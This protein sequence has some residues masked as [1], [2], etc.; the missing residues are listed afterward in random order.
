MKKCL[1]TILCASTA[2]VLC[3]CVSVA[4][5]SS[6]NFDNFSPCASNCNAVSS[7]SDCGNVVYEIDDF[8]SSSN[9]SITGNGSGIGCQY[10]GYVNPV[11]L[12]SGTNSSYTMCTEYK[13][14][15]IESAYVLYL[16]AGNA[17][18][19]D[20]TIA[21]YDAGTCTPPSGVSITHP[22][23]TLPGKAIGLTPGNDYVVCHTYT[24]NGCAGTSNIYETCISIVEASYCTSSPDPSALTE[25]CSGENFEIT[26]D[27][28][29]TTDPDF[30]DF[31]DGLPGFAVFY[32]LDGQ[33]RYTNF[34]N[35][36]TAYNL[37]GNP[38]VRFYDESNFANGGGC[39]PIRMESKDNT[40]CTPIDIPVGI[41]GIDVNSVDVG[42]INI[43]SD[44]PV[45]GAT[46][47][48]HPQL[49]SQVTGSNIQLIS[50]GGTVCDTYSNSSTSS[51][52][53]TSLHEIVFGGGLSGSVLNG[54]GNPLNQT[55]PGRGE[56]GNVIIPGTFGGGGSGAT[57]IPDN[58]PCVTP[59]G[60]GLAVNNND[61]MLLEH[62]VEV[63]QEGHLVFN[64]E[65]PVQKAKLY[66]NPASG[67]L[68]FSAGISDTYTVR[69]YDTLGKQVFTGQTN[70]DAAIDIQ[71]LSSGLYTYALED[72]RQNIFDY[73]KWVKK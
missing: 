3:I 28:M 50:Q 19:I 31:T 36:M 2:F 8:A 20:R 15:S 41:V 5:A 14:S 63:N 12:S 18:C 68:F 53:P 67:Q 70:D 71:H 42:L 4:N 69:I 51:G 21:V 65:L 37:Q 58:I 11:Q 56:T 22:F 46:L 30:Y 29:C 38:N 54:S 33:G 32:Y 43:I 55:R 7:A 61:E 1:F 66:P 9:N 40:D 35:N 59:S 44:C 13:A 23:A 45:V 57:T 64:Y 62:T 10:F 39:S 47:R 25:A 73:G 16:N 27:N 52:Y 48:I 24:H 6:D 17:G 26:L 49:T 60:G 72:N 34:P